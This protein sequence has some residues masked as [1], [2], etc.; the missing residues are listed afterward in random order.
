MGEVL[1]DKE[2]YEY[3]RKNVN[4]GAKLTKEEMDEG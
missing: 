2:R 3:L 1:M 4:D